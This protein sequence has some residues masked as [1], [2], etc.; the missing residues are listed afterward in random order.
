MNNEKLYTFSEHFAELKKRFLLCFI[1]L[2][3]ASLFS[4]TLSEKIFLFLLEPLSS[5]IEDHEHRK[6][7]YT[8]LTEAFFTYIKLSIFAGF[9]ISFPFMASQIYVFLAPGLYRS[10]K[11]LLLSL[12]ISSP[13]LFFIGASVLYY[14]I[15]PLAWKFF[16]SFETYGKDSIPLQLEARIS[17][18]LSLTIELIIAFGLAFQLPLALIL[19]VKLGVINQKWLKKQRKIAIIIAFVIGAILTPPDIISQIGLAIPLL[20]L[21]ELAIFACYFI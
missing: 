8:G 6:I 19:L 21:Y 13:V 14:L 5:A 12:V 20:L 4:Y 18:Y 15:L 3:A 17:E 9:V 11:K 7:I 2:I 16:L 1:I 10:E